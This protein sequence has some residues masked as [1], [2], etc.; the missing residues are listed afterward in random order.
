MN[1]YV[2]HVVNEAVSKL[3]G[4]AEVSLL[5]SGEVLDESSD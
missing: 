2:N 3:Q 4:W 5:L 1:G